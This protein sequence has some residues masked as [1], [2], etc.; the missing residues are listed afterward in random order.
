MSLLAKRIAEMRRR[1]WLTLSA[2][3]Q[4]GCLDRAT[5]YRW[6]ADKKLEATKVAGNRF[7]SEKSLRRE[8][9][10]MRCLDRQKAKT[11]GK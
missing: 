11:C 8:L 1:G 9:D 4:E 10:P 5:I 7:V 3:A 6:I 2:A